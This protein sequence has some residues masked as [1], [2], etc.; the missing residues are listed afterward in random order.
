MLLKVWRWI[1]P[2]LIIG[3]VMVAAIS[4]GQ[5]ASDNAQQIGAAQAE[6]H[7]QDKQIDSL[8]SS[9]ADANKKLSNAG[10]PTVP[11]VV[12]PSNG[13]NGK[14]GADGR[15]VLS[16]TCEP[17]GMW[18]VTYDDGAT[19]PAGPGCVGVQGIQGVAG[20]NGTNGQDSTVPGPQGPQGEPGAA[21]TVPGPAGPAGQAPYSWTYTDAHN[22]SYTCN[23]A[24]P[25]DPSAPT[26]T[27]GPTPVPPTEGET[28]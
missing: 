27:C 7:A 15:S 6:N 8:V 12:Q 21:S 5:K 11:V 4:L 1:Y 24:D 28:K 19:V 13:T 16:T 17:S 3:A 10:L 14:D 2:V 26:Y 9:L 22:I 25:F 18:V 20:Q 23:R